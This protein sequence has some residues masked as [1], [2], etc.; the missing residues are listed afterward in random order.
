MMVRVEENG[1]GEGVSGGRTSILLE[2]TPH[3]SQALRMEQTGDARGTIIQDKTRQDK[4]RQESRS[5]HTKQD[6]SPPHLVW[7][8]RSVLVLFSGFFSGDP[9]RDRTQ[10]LVIKMWNPDTL[11]KN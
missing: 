5:D 2:P 9:P 11:R 7:C 10:L 4:T 1:E 8:D 3:L 6:K